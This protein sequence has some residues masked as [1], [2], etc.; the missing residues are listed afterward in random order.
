MHYS[1]LYIISY[2]LQSINLELGGEVN[3]FNIMA[4]HSIKGTH[5]SHKGEEHRNSL[6]NKLLLWKD[7]IIFE[8]NLAI[9]NGFLALFLHSTSKP[10]GNHSDIEDNQK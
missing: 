4:R 9:A 8:I 1:N 10:H 5:E 2:L 6:M 3:R 7:K